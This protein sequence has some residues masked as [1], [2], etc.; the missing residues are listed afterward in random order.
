[1]LADTKYI[2]HFLDVF[3]LATVKNLNQ[4]FETFGVQLFSHLREYL[5][6]HN[7]ITTERV[8]NLQAQDSL[9]KPGGRPGNCH[10]APIPMPDT[11]CFEIARSDNYGRVL[12]VGN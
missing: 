6:T 5:T 2:W 11:V 10:S 7:K 3:D 1:M 12:E 4:D 8:A 9:C